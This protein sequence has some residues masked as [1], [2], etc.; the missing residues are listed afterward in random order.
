MNFKPSGRKIEYGKNKG[1]DILIPNI[2][3]E[4]DIY[5]KTINQITLKEG[6]K[7]LDDVQK[8]VIFQRYYD[9]KTQMEIAEEFNISQAQVSRIEKNALKVLKSFFD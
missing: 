7:H 6:V 8:K 9:G 2:K 4:K 1:E 3:D 5:E